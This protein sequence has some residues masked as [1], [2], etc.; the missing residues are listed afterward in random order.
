MK[1]ILRLLLIDRYMMG[2]KI[3]KVG[4]QALATMFFAQA[5]GWGRSA[6][7]PPLRS[8]SF[9]K[10]EEPTNGAQLRRRAYHSADG[11][12]LYTLSAY[13]VPG[14]PTL[15]AKPRSQVIEP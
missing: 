10:A 11:A 8:Q 1:E 12:K 7:L 13:L 4:S 14:R 2:S 15:A 9:F 6:R 5:A 3:L